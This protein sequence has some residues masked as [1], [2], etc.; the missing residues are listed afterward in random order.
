MG[1]KRV[2]SREPAGEP[3]PGPFG[4][5]VITGILLLPH[6]EHQAPPR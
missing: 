3:K 4:K 2:Q 5:W 1:Y 6:K